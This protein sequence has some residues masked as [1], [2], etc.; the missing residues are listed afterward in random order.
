V[1][2]NAVLD[3]GKTIATGTPAEV[4]RDPAVVA[5]YIGGAGEGGPA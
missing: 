4:R 1:W 5:A 3:F 2:S